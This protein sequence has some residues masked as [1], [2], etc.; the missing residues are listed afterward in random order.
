M[1]IFDIYWAWYAL[2][3]TGSITLLFAPSI[4]RWIVR[5]YP[6]TSTRPKGE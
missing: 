4:A 2:Y 1:T 6:P 5:R 3:A